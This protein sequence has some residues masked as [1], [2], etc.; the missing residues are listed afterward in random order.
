MFKDWKAHDEERSCRPSVCV[1]IVSRLSRKYGS[2]ESQNPMV[3]HGQLQ[4]Q[5]I[6]I[7]NETMQKDA[8][9]RY[10]VRT[11]IRNKFLLCNYLDIRNTYRENT[12][13]IKCVLFSAASVL[14][15]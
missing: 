14:S 15:L 5:F 6:Y 9:M 13:N 4:G 12:L 1:Y 11:Y 10:W 8:Q 2:L 7:K 3:L